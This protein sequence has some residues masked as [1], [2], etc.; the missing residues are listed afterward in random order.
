LALG[1]PIGCH[2]TI[3][4]DADDIR[5]SKQSEPK[6]LL[7]AITP[8]TPKTSEFPHAVQP[9]GFFGFMAYPII[10]H[11]SPALAFVASDVDF[12]VDFH[13]DYHTDVNKSTSEF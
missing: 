7:E 10:H 12:H 5:P 4:P 3:L 2:A 9:I 1:E 11:A 13:V 8:D 6:P